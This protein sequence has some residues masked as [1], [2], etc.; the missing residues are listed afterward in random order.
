MQT[1]T[2]VEQATK[3]ARALEIARAYWA[4]SAEVKSRTGERCLENVVQAAEVI[5]ASLRGGGKLLICGN[6]GSAADSQHLAGEFVSVLDRRFRR[7]ALAAIALTTDTSI[8]TAVANDF[9][10]GGIFERQVEALGRQ[11]DALLGI[12]TSGN[13]ECVVRAMEV[14]RRKQ[15]ST[16]ALTGAT[17]GELLAIADISIC[18]PSDS[19]QHIQEMHLTVEHLITLL[20]EQKLFGDG[21]NGH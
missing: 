2:A 1:D 9:G 13:S 15:I 19:V 20:V 4:S 14:A 10:Y 12:S 6:G 18:I 3:S 8:I 7:P 21:S 11:G 16:I 17:G 5:A